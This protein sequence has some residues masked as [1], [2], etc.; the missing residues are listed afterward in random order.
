MRARAV[1]AFS[2]AMAIDR[3]IWKGTIARNFRGTDR[4][5]HAK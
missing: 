2:K 1:S 5:I 3:D 4:E